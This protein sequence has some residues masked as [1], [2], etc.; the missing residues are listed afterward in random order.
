MV[1]T[2]D[3]DRHIDSA[4]HVLIDDPANGRTIAVERGRGE[5]IVS[6]VRRYR[7]A[8]PVEQ[9]PHP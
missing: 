9:P 3:D 7:P 4:T 8:H 1:E 5:S 6:P 2:T